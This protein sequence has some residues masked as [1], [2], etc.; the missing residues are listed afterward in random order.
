MHVKSALLSA[1][2]ASSTMA[3]VAPKLFSCGTPEP[4][5]EHKKLSLALA[6]QEK[7]MALA[8]NDTFTTMATISVDVYFHVVAA[9]TALSDGYVT[10]S[11]YRAMTL[12]I[13]TDFRRIPN[14]PT[15]SR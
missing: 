1:L 5:E 8:S 14:S 13:C 12:Y 2:A 15:S 7:E 6:T 9:S 3:A 11:L 10:V 4:S